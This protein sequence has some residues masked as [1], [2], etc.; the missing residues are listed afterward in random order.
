MPHLAELETSVIR[1]ILKISSK[2]GVIS[3]AG[4]LPASELFPLD[5]LQQA[6]EISIQKYGSGS[7]QYSLTRGV[8]ALRELLAKRATERGTK[9]SID[10]ILITAGA[11]QGLE[12][13][14]R[15]FISP[16]DYI[17]TENPTYVG[18]LQ[19]F[20]YY[21]ARYATVP[22]DNDGMMVDR[23]PGLIE[24][25]SPKLIY[26]VSNF[27]NPTGISLSKERREQLNE[28]AGSYNIPLIDDNPYGEVRFE[29]ERLPTLK[30]LGGDEVI[31]LR[32]FSK[33]VAPGLRIGWMNGPAGIMGQFEKIKQCTDLHTNTLCQ[34]MMY[35]YVM[36]G[37]LDPHIE[38]IKTDYRK[39]RNVMLEAME[40]NFP[41][42]IVWTKPKGG[43]FLW[44][45]LPKHMS[46]KAILEKAFEMKVAYVY[47]EPFFANEGGENCLRLT[48]SNASHEE[49][50]LGIER[51][52]RL[53][54]EN[55]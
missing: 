14:A 13:I 30:A 15:A 1:E 9:S 50:V 2:P 41:T 3:F 44:V 43:L 12:L 45:E 6:M 5:D 31:A 38:R 36:A 54:K 39:K 22:M 25:Y 40:A 7:M 26:T 16:G 48:F 8:A 33:I 11:Q 24:K 18:A 52:G 42:E 47:G 35:E 34:Y 20:N 27:Q 17:I 46:A 37:K 29:G 55:M 10:N 21:Q 4:G 49:I 23:I 32:T 19:A 53:F 51:L 28:I